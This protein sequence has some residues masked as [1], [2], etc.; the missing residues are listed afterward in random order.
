VFEC[1]S[2]DQAR[3]ETW[4]DLQDST[5][6]RRQDWGG[7]APLDGERETDR[8]TDSRVT[9]GRPNNMSALGLHNLNSRAIEL[10]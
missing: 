6:P 10:N 1:P 4:P 5:S 9:G 2:H 8:Q 3:R 7:D